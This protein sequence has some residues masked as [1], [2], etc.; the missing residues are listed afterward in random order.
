MKSENQGEIRKSIFPGSNSPMTLLGPNSP[1]VPPSVSLLASREIPWVPDSKI[2][3]WRESGTQGTREKEMSKINI[4]GAD[5]RI[6]PEVEG[7]GGNLQSGRQE[8]RD[9]KFLGPLFRKNSLVFQLNN[10]LIHMFPTLRT[11][12]EKRVHL[13]QDK[14]RLSCRKWGAK[15]SFHHEGGGGSCPQLQPLNPPLILTIDDFNL[16]SRENKVN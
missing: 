4:N 1:R 6:Q 13:G 3:F 11:K 8:Y 5:G 7:G 12:H 2:F 15:L 16:L 9:K 14:G 10:A